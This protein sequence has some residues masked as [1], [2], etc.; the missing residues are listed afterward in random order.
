M[1]G[2]DYAVVGE[3]PHFV[4]PFF[5]FAGIRIGSV[6]VIYYVCVVDVNVEGGVEGAL[7]W[8]DMVVCK[9]EEARTVDGG[10]ELKWGDAEEC[11]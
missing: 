1:D 6:V 5:W 7:V 11:K 3:E 8:K 2:V 9:F 10:S 4:A